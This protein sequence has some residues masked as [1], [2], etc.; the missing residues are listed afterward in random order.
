MILQSFPHAPPPPLVLSDSARWRRPTTSN[1]LEVA[2]VVGN[3][4][5][6]AQALAEVGCREFERANGLEQ[7]ACQLQETVAALAQRQ[8]TGAGSAGVRQESNSLVSR[9]VAPQKAYQQDA[10]Q[11]I[12]PSVQVGKR[13]RMRSVQFANLFSEGDR[14]MGS[15]RTHDRSP[16]QQCRGS[17]TT[18]AALILQPAREHGDWNRNI[19]YCRKTFRAINPW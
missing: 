10:L 4:T 9:S 15:E 6:A 2:R 1:W 3:P 11:T 18:C 7:T 5:R 16:A 13:S 17:A 14:G 8:R 19:L 12:E